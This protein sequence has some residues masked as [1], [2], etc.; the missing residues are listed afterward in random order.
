MQTVS[1]QNVDHGVGIRLPALQ[2]N[3]SPQWRAVIG[4]TVSALGIGF[5]ANYALGNV[6]SSMSWVWI[7]LALAAL[8]VCLAGWS[9]YKASASAKRER[10]YRDILDNVD[11]DRKRH[12]DSSRPQ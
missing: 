9:A 1:Q 5:A 7:G 10:E 3:L 4:V 8:A 6:Q 12:Y 11:R 2:F